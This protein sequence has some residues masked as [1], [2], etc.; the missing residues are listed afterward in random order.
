MDRAVQGYLPVDQAKTRRRTVDRLSPSSGTGRRLG[1]AGS[2]PA[3]LPR[4]CARREPRREHQQPDGRG[5]QRRL[6]IFLKP[7]RVETPQHDKT[8]QQEDAS[9]HVETPQHG[10][11]PQH[12]WKLLKPKQVETPQ[13]DWKDVRVIGVHEQSYREPTELLLQLSRHM[14]DLFTNQPTRRFAHGFFLRGTEIELW[15]FDRSGPYSPREFDIHEEP[16]RFII[17]LAGYACKQ[18]PFCFLP[19]L[20]VSRAVSTAHQCS[21]SRLLSGL[22]N[23]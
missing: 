1:V 6:N 12:D 5:S 21:K 23:Y 7:K 2:I 8:P 17:S 9:Q 22:S 3:R 15:V 10:E 11:T 19:P 14:R 18:L 20:D 13:H 4:R 16:E